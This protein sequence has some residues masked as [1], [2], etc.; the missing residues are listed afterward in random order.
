MTLISDERQALAGT[1]RVADPHAAT[2]CAGWDVRRLLAHLV[3]RESE[4]LTAIKDVVARKPPGAEPGLTRLVEAAST[5]SAYQALVSRFAAGPSR[6]SPRNWVDQQFNLV[7]YIIHHEDIRR[8]GPG[9]IEPRALPADV[10]GAA[11]KSLGLLAWLNLR[12]SPVGVT[13]AAPTGAAQVAKKGSTGV[14]LTGDPVELA[15]YLSGRRDQARV[16]LTGPDAPVKQF[17][18]WI[19]GT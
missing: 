10:H 16:R 13:L 14:T 15:L 8:A 2:L 9:A 7:E 12:K 5:P 17:V 11:W 18:T 6:W 3:V 1:L 19:V 4:P